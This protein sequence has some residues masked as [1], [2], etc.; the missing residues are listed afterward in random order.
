MAKRSSSLPRVAYF[1][2]E[3]A[4]QSDVKL[5]AGGLGI[6]TAT[7]G[8]V[9]AAL[10]TLIVEA[11]SI[12][13][14]LS[15]G[16]ISAKNIT[17]RPTTAGTGINI[18]STAGPTPGLLE[19]SFNELT[20]VVASHFIF[21]ADGSPAYPGAPAGTITFSINMSKSGDSFTFVTAKNIVLP[22]GTGWGA[23]ASDI[24]LR[25]NQQTTPT[26]G[27]FAGIDMDNAT[28]GS[29]SG[30]ITLLGRGGDDS[31]GFQYGVFIRGGSNVSAGSSDSVTVNG[32]GGASDGESNYG[33]AVIGIGSKITSGGGAVLVTGQGG[34]GAGGKNHGVAIGI[35]GQIV[36]GG[37]ISV[38]GTGGSGS[39]GSSNMGVLV[40]TGAQ[41]SAGGLQPVIVQGVGGSGG[42]A[43]NVG[44]Y[45]SNAATIDSSGGP[46]SITATG[47]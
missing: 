11:D 4:L 19:L 37:A 32:T 15:A 9:D 8:G 23:A 13:I 22:S 33:V 16:S 14:A 39:A 30:K 44:V 12:D 6:Q 46:V 27:N 28:I 18:G 10:A 36:S 21:G 20:N 42:V 38:M 40:Y 26:T 41:I 29:T 24:T 43:N 5:Y 47:N 35:G 3:Y 45:V 7:G 31:S 34:G 25:A 1:C 2:M 17:F